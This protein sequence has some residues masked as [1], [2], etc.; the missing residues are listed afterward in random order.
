MATSKTLAIAKDARIAVAGSFEAG[1]GASSYLPVGVYSGYTYRALLQPTLDWAG[2]V[3]LVGA[4]LKLKVSGQYYVSFSSDPD[5]KAQRLTSAWTEGTAVAL[6]SSNAVHWGN[7]P[8]ATAVG[9]SPDTDI[10]VVDG[11]WVEIDVIDIVEAWAPASVQKRDGSPGGAQTNYGL[12]LIHIDSGDVTEFYSS[13]SSYDPFITLTYETNRPPNAPTLLEPVGG[14]TDASITFRG[15]HNDPDGD[16]LNAWEVEADTDPA[17]GSPEL[18]TGMSTGGISGLGFTSGAW[19][20]SALRGQTLN[21]RARTR[22]PELAVGPWATTS[23]FINRLPT[24]TKVRPTASQF[25][26]IWNLEELAV[27]TAGGAHAK[28]QLVWAFAD[29]DGGPQTAF[30][31]RIYSAATA[32]TLLHDSGKV[33]S[34][35]TIYDATW[36]GVAGTEYWWTIEVWDDLD[37]SSGESSRTAFKMRF[38]QAIYEHNPGAGSSSWTFSNSPISNGEGSFAFAAATGAAGTGRSA[39][40]A[41][42]GALTPSA[43][44][45][46]LVRLQPNAA[47]GTTPT[48][49]D[50]Q[51]SYLG[52]AATPD[53]WALASTGGSMSLDPSIRRYGTQCL[54]VVCGTGSTWIYPYRMALGDD[55]QIQPNTTYTFSAWVKTNGATGGAG[56]YL[57]ILRGGGAASL[58]SG[59]GVAGA[60]TTD[61]SPYA[62]GWQRLVLTFKT[63]PTTT[64]V[65]PRLFSS[66]AGITF[67]ADALKLEE[68]TVATPWAPGFVGDP[69]VLDS[70]G[71]AVDAAAGGIFRARGSAGGSRDQFELGPRGLLFTDVELWSPAAEQLQVGDGLNPQTLAIEGGTSG[72]KGG[73]LVLMGSGANADWSI[74]NSSGDLRAFSAAGTAVT[75]KNVASGGISM[76][77]TDRRAEMQAL[78]LLFPG[79]APF[80]DFRNDAVADFDARLI[81]DGDDRLTLDGAALR[82]EAMAPVVSSF[83]GVATD[84]PTALTF[85]LAHANA[86]IT[87]TP[88]FV[89]QRFRCEF[90]GS[91][92]LPTHVGVWQHRLRIT[93]AANATVADLARVVNEDPAASVWKPTPISDVWVADAVATRKLRLM[94]TAD[95]NGDDVTTEGTLILTPIP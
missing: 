28:P 26:H 89:G 66:V 62:E 69:V 73:E 14:R 37:E 60:F 23:T 86:E 44:V 52:S 83:S 76:V 16:P 49:P 32:G 80:I 84:V 61:S 12:R 50:M 25:A 4:K 42:V 38:A 72:S 77:L 21:W 54:K 75:L 70:N 40:V 93:D 39:W 35:A 57:E 34:G 74:D 30:R 43:Y 24:A 2:V 71:I 7:Q 27:W 11:T 92:F 8:T 78:E 48:L 20:A 6:S 13:D 46:V 17:F 90:H 95:T 94:T 33:L 91:S 65:R 47:P 5:V 15:R 68:G 87:F 45:N 82:A 53:R 36:A 67:W 41:S 9:E 51:F 79:G 18:D 63:G 3:K 22:D 55:I 59:S 88:A 10:S 81:L 19:D 31:V 1:A 29:L 56:I 85:V 64:I 58:F